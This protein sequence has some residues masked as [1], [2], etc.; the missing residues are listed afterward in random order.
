LF[1]QSPFQPALFL[2]KNNWDEPLTDYRLQVYAGVQGSSG[3]PRQGEIIV[4]RRTLNYL[5][6]IGPFDH[7]PTPLKLG[8]VTIT[9]AVGERLTLEAADGTQFY[10][11]VATRQWV[12]PQTATSEP[13][14]P[15]TI[16]LEDKYA[17]D[18]ERATRVAAIPSATRYWP[19]P[20][21]T[22]DLTP[23]WPPD[24]PYR[25]AGAGFILTGVQ[26]GM[27]SGDFKDTNLWVERLPD[28]NI[29]VFAG[30]DGY[31]GDPTQGLLVIIIKSP[32][33][34]PIGPVETY[35]TPTKAGPVTIT[36]AVGE[37][38]TLEAADGT[39][40]YFDVATRQWVHP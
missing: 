16:F 38:L 24:V 31:I 34:V 8:P 26:L 32:D 40:F 2:A 29:G 3:D 25:A 36:D 18:R 28:R 4:F 9:D 12:N 33:R 15:S 13:T 35:R 11:D 6:F 23:S 22:P 14:P 17:A 10:F 39:R 7:Y 37:R 20:T 19:L 5:E 1:T 27:S 21:V 30:G